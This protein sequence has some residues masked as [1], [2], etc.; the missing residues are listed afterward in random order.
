[1]SAELVPFSERL[2]RLLYER[3]ITAAEL[4]RK[5]N[6]SKASISHYLKG[7]WKAKQDAVYK[8][9]TACDCSEVWLMGADVPMDSGVAERKT[10]EQH[11]TEL[12]ESLREKQRMLLSATSDLDDDDIDILIQLAKKINKEYGAD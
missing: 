6:I 12:L 3:N 8:I 7:D 2:K 10:A 5:T 11:R 4:S 1:M 9:A